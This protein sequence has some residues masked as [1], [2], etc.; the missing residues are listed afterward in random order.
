MFGLS[1]VE[2]D[3]LFL[4]EFNNE[5]DINAPIAAVDKFKNSLLSIIFF[6]GGSVRDFVLAL[7]IGVFIGTYSS[8]FL[9]SPILVVW[10]KLKK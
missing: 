1:R 7:S 4:H 2:R 3:V 5:P 10:E 6:G 8:I 9:A